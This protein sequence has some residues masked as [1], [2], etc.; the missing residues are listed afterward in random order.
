[1]VYSPVY[2]IE[3]VFTPIVFIFYVLFGLMEVADV[4]EFVLVIICKILTI[5]VYYYQSGLDVALFCG[6]IICVR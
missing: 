6:S 3:G 4:H 1:M 2:I 5:E